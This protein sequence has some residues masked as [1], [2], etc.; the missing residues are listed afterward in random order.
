MQSGNEEN[1]DKCSSQNSKLA[2]LKEVPGKKEGVTI[3]GVEYLHVCLSDG[4]ELYLTKYG[5]PIASYLLPENF[6]K[7]KEWFRS[8][9]TK[10]FGGIHSVG[11]ST[12]YRVRTK[13]IASRSKDIVLKWNRM[14]QDVPG[15]ED[16]DCELQDA[17]FNSPYEEFALVME[18]RD[19]AYESPGRILTHKPLAIYVPSRRIDPSESARKEYKMQSKIGN[20]HDVKLDMLRPYAVIYEWLEGVDAAEAYATGGIDK[21][22]MQNLTLLAESEIRGKGF[23]VRDRKPHH[24][25]VRFDKAGELLADRS[26]RVAYA[27]VDFELLERTSEREEKVRQAKRRG[28]LLKQASRFDLQPS[29]PIPSH[30]MG[31]HI[32][33]VDYVH[34]TAESTGGKLWVVG[35]DSVLFDYFLPERWEHTPRTRLSSEDEIYETMTK[36]SI[37]VVWKVSRVGLRPDMDPFKENEKRIIEHGYN[38][39]FEDVALALSLSR[40]GVM[41]TYPRAIYMTG[42]SSEIA[43]SLSDGSRYETHAD[44]L[45][46]DGTPVLRRDRDYVIIWGYWNKPDELLARDDKDHYRAIDALR[47]LRE[48]LLTEDGYMELMRRT[49]AKLAMI[50][51]EALNIGGNH[52]LLSLDSSGQF[53]RDTDGNIA[54]RI[55]SFEL[56]R[57]LVS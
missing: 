9:S 45:L 18:M 50:G 41:T 43:R 10:L 49:K 26:G 33:G 38:S 39:P 1:R 3:L 14:G 56:L 19:T 4:D 35:K 28:Y 15:A 57:E 55:C 48:G 44:L 16:V 21:D 5:A 17:E 31:M 32:F 7:D 12:V 22:T 54:V 53:V 42:H 27:V 47:A 40:R 23:I 25:I 34:G 30:L 46:P 11:T 24:I 29:G 51:V 2:V 52:K 20:H 8:H 6:W 13:S 36:D 37:H